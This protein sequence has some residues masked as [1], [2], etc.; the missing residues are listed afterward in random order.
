MSRRGGYNTIYFE[1]SLTQDPD[2]GMIECVCEELCVKSL[3]QVSLHIN[4]K[5]LIPRQWT[6]DSCTR[7]PTRRTQCQHLHPCSQPRCPIIA[8]LKCFTQLGHVSFKASTLLVSRLTHQNANSSGGQWQDIFSPR[9]YKEIVSENP[10]KE[11]NITR[12][13]ASFIKQSYNQYFN[14][15]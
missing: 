7:P 12:V 8:F 5:S 13:G 4:H 15:R 2:A 3:F 10:L 6:I 11:H 9:N 14:L 1:G